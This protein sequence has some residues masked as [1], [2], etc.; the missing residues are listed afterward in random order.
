M[1][2]TEGSTARVGESK[3]DDAPSKVD[4]ESWKREFEQ[5][6]GP[7]RAAFHDAAIGKAIVD[8]DGSWLHV[9]KSL[10]DI[11]GYNP[12]ELLEID[13]QTLTHPDDLAPDLAL[14]NQ[15]LAGKIPNYHLEKRYYHKRGHIVWVLLSV[16]LIRDPQ[17]RPCYF[18]SQV[19][20]ITVRKRAE[21][22]FR[23]LLESAPDAMVIVNQQGQ[24]ALVNSQTEKMFGYDRRELLGQPVE[25]LLPARFRGNHPLHHA[26]Y[27]SNPRS[28]DAA[29]KT[30]LTAQRSDG[31][32]FPAEISFAPLDT[33]EGVLVSSAIRDITQR[34]L[35][36]REARLHL[37]QE[38]LAKHRAE[39][40]H[41]LRVNTMGEMAAGIAHELNQPL[42]AIINYAKGSVR[43]LQDGVG[44]QSDIIEAAVAIAGE[45]A[46]AS[47]IVRGLKR[48]IHKC[49]PQRTTVDINVVVS[50][51][52]Q[53]VSGE[54][55]QHGVN[56]GLRCATGL[57]NLLGDRVQLE[58]VVVNL[59][60]NGIQSLEKAASD[61]RVLV[62]TKQTAPGQV[63]IS[64][65]DNG[66]GLPP[67][68]ESKIFEAFFT[69]KP[70]GLG[71]GLAISRSIVEAHRGKLWAEANAEGGA[72]FHFTLPVQQELQ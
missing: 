60:V 47:E 39:L 43:R 57:P 4:L 7:F 1:Q 22:K 10:C 53:I 31:S 16:S 37:Q 26:E 61:R 32:E 12:A 56:V 27:F 5:D 35:T 38:E 8:L 52:G 14:V 33:E 28:E 58:Q 45:A 9:N 29:S 19:Q 30:E 48:Y 23:G 66:C 6:G 13:F 50:N 51:A 17:L 55:H 64:V 25:L 67:E 63:R 46:R 41:V 3:S 49:E 68:F 62:Q 71:M 44:S 54:A 69:T 70:E 36:E 59:M 24:I 65:T 18:I 15:L 11:V 40:A 42:A 72:T 21:E 2:T 20:D 34:V